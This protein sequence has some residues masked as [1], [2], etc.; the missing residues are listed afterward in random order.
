MSGSLSFFELRLQVGPS[1]LDLQEISS[2]YVKIIRAEVLYRLRRLYGDMVAD[3]ET[4][5][6]LVRSILPQSTTPS[7]F[8]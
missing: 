3:T 2:D 8:P 6:Y 5:H 7:E 1:R 4:P